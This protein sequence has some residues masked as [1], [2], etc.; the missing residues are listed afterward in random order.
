MAYPANIPCSPGRL[1]DVLKMCLQDVFFEED[2]LQLCLENVLK[3]NVALRVHQDKCLLGRF[4]R[5]HHNDRS[6]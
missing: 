2:V 3:D 6:C 5:V 4:Y 1:Q